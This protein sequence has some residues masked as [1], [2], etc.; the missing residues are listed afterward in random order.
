MAN[1]VAYDY[2]VPVSV[3]SP[4]VAQSLDYLRS[5]YVVCKGLQ[6][7]SG[8]AVIVVNNITKEEDILLHTSSLGINGLFDGGLN[9]INLICLNELATIEDAR[10]E[11]KTLENKTLTILVHSDVQDSADLIL[12][13]CNITQNI[14]IAKIFTV[15]QTNA[16]EPRDIDKFAA[17]GCAFVDD[18][19]D[20]KAMFFYFASLLSFPTFNNHQYDTMPPALGNLT[21]TDVGTA[22]LYFNNRYSFAID[23]DGTDLRELGFFVCGGRSITDKYLTEEIKRNLQYKLKTY[24]NTNKPTKTA[25]NLIDLRLSAAT[26]FTEYEE[27][28]QLIPGVNT[29]TVSDEGEDYCADGT[30]YMQL[31]QA[32][33]RTRFTINVS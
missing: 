2:A 20:K 26:I 12:D 8:G 15:A 18:S 29:V 24:I 30:I 28:G 3:S 22:E 5:V 4:V 33:W 11:I 13:V 9:V 27:S 23:G 21:V 10:D 32:L 14:T 31:A 17:M 7:E 19:T 16:E 1:F 25:D 6:S